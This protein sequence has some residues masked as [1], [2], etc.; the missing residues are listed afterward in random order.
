[1]A[2]YCRWLVLSIILGPFRMLSLFQV[3]LPILGAILVHGAIIVFRP[4]VILGFT[5]T[6][7]VTVVC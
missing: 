2:I 5:M 3:V 6:I 7:T 1:M 4:E